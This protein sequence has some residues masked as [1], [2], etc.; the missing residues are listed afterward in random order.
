[1]KI[2]AIGIKNLASL[3]GAS[4]IDFTQEPLCSAGIF[5]ITGPTGAG[6]STILDAVCLALYGKTPRYLQGKE[7]GIDVFDTSGSTIAQ[8][9]VRGI[10]RDG[11]ADGYA[12]V[13]FVATDGER[14]RAFW[15]VKR[16]YNRVDGALQGET[17]SLTNLNSGLPFAGRKTEILKELERLVGL[18]FEQFTRSVLLAQGDFTAF[19]KASKDEKASLLE[20]LTGNYIYTE[21]SKLVFEKFKAA[22]QV[23]R[24]LI[25]QKEAFAFLDDEQRELLEQQQG[26]LD[27]QIAELTIVVTGLE[28]E[29][30]WH[31]RRLELDQAVTAAAATLS[32]AVGQK[33]N[34]A[35]RYRQLQRINETQQCRSWV[36]ARDQSATQQ[37]HKSTA[38]AALK[39]NAGLLAADQGKAQTALDL[40]RTAVAQSKT[41]RS[42][43]I[44]VLEQ[45]KRLDVLISERRE[46]AGKAESA[47]KEAT[48]KKESHDLKETEKIQ[49]VSQLQLRIDKL[50]DWKEANKHREPLSVHFTLISSKL[51]DAAN[52]FSTSVQVAADLEKN[53]GLLE[54]TTGSIATATAT[55]A[56]KN[57][58]LSDKKAAHELKYTALKVIAIEELNQRKATT[59]AAVEDMIRA[60]AQWQLLA[61]ELSEQKRI[62]ERLTNNR[63]AAEIKD[64]QLTSGRENLAAAKIQKDTSAK[65]LETARL[66]VADNVVSLR[67]SLKTEEP[68]PVCGSLEHPY[69][70]HE[71]MLDSVLA[72]I[73]AECNQQEK[74][75]E[76]YFQAVSK[77]SNELGVLH[78]Q[79]AND[80]RLLHEKTA[81]I[82][83]HNDRWQKFQV[84]AVC[85]PVA[86]EDK[87]TWLLNKTREIK[88]EQ[89]G[90]A[91]Q[92]SGFNRAQQSLESLG[93][94]ISAEE[95]LI[96]GINKNLG[97]KTHEHKTLTET[98]GRLKQELNK[99]NTDL[100]A[101]Q[102]ELNPHFNQSDWFAKW[103]E[104]PEIFLRQLSLFD[105]Q[106]RKQI[107]QLETDTGAIK[108]ARAELQGLQQQTVELQAALNKTAAAFEQIKGALLTETD[109]RA[110]LFAGRPTPDIE[111]ELD[112]RI[113]SAE[114]QVKLGEKALQV[115]KDK[116]TQNKAESEQ[117]SKD[118]M[119][120]GKAI[121]QNAAKIDNWLENYNLKHSANSI[122]VSE[123]EQLLS[124]SFEWREN[125]NSLLK[126]LDEAWTA[127]KS[128]EKERAENLAAHLEKRI[129]AKEPVEVSLLLAEKKAVVDDLKHQKSEN[130][131]KLEHDEQNKVKARQLVLQIAEK[132]EV[133]DNWG[134]LNEM[135]GSADG[136]KFRQ[137][138]QEFTLDVLLTFANIH[139]KI[140]SKRYH[141]GRIPGTLGLQVTDRDMGDEL[142]TIFSLSGGESFLVSLA[143]ALGLAELSSSKMNVE[144]LFIDEG[145]GSL[146]PQTLTVAM[147]ALEGLHNQGRKVGVISHVQEM[148]ER[149][150]AQIQV[151]KL[152]NG[153][154]EIKIDLV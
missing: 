52:L 98:I 142:R 90:L 144:S 128:V 115:V 61:R 3:E 113:N 104:E 57:T 29:H 18:N 37:N 67:G 147:G 103:Q 45:A 23:L 26:L 7:T 33:E 99:S 151:N 132:Q 35:P 49:Q 152:A 148:T 143:L 118:L 110:G 15:K 9:D 95:L 138:A 13:D 127:A 125:E 135:I 41:D 108:I 22:E 24:E 6:K 129:S 71:P 107:M 76:G 42:A 75:Y 79:N 105:G 149:I 106:W 62:E 78:D 54:T 91:E 19:L 153:K 133:S 36:E 59:D 32:A 150:P 65:L 126:K 69:A 124:Y 119:A 40:R 120:L 101:L 16:A 109:Q 56:E 81:L 10:L 122:T 112:A 34:A 154:S 55:L 131:F 102:T 4:T 92:I 72:A 1:M 20:K 38:L 47:F 46:Q 130:G 141:I 70:R 116:I 97:I 5:A 31:L 68:C 96:A 146:D 83:T 82:S 140:L 85:N 111:Q 17:L 51:R 94:E 63:S 100:G 21:I 53:E 43:A 84:Y 73:E 14:Y 86:D 12:E 50:E 30:S 121:E 58:A 137:I 88:K 27:Q 136:K 28:Q 80:E 25:L 74:A 77:L 44:P 145:F 8:G 139:L 117:A 114:E 39:E 123:L 93:K 64:G 60:T 2:L 134:R 48:G 66:K 87:E 89:Q 11:T